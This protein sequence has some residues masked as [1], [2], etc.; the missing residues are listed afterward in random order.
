MFPSINIYFY[1]T[2]NTRNVLHSWGG[3]AAV[4]AVGDTVQLTTAPDAADWEVKRIIWSKPDP[5]GPQVVD[6]LITPVP[7]IDLLR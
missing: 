6:I 1:R 7:K 5:N 4:P 2:T 3:C